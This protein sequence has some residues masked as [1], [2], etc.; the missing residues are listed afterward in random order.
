M[1]S[2]IHWSKW[3]VFHFFVVTKWT[4][5]M[6]N[7]CFYFLSVICTQFYQPMEHR[8]HVNALAALKKCTPTMYAIRHCK[9]G[10]FGL[11]VVYLNHTI[12]S[13]RN[14]LSID[15]TMISFLWILLAGP[16]IWATSEFVQYNRFGSQHGRTVSFGNDLGWSTLLFSWNSSR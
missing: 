8:F 5:W 4:N 16:D 12:Q 11:W 2:I 14:C 9:T 1:H 3:G 6:M 13:L 10:N 15:I 7:F